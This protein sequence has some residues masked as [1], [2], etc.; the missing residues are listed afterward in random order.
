[1]R[2]TTLI[3][4]LIIAMML[5]MTACAEISYETKT[6]EA[7]VISCEEGTFFPEENYLAQANICLAFKKLEVSVYRCEADCW[8]HF[9]Y[10]EE[11]V[12]TISYNDV[13]TVIVRL[14][15]YEIGSTISLEATLEYSDGVLT[16]IECD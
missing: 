7:T 11:D 9:S 13:E 1:M 15:Q 4:I 8:D 6:I 16:R 12:L 5:S 10:R 3:I 14:D 2:K